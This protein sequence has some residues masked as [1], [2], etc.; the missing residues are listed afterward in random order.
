MGVSP[1]EGGK[2]VGVKRFAGRGMVVG[3]LKTSSLCRVFV[4]AGVVHDVFGWEGLRAISSWL[5][6]PG[7]ENTLGFKALRGVS[8]GAMEAMGI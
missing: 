2:W 5:R 6:F 3:V 8:G 7:V 1:G 4:D